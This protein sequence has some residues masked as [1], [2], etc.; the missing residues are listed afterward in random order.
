MAIQR[1]R[2]AVSP[3]D[4]LPEDFLS[5]ER[6]ALIIDGDKRELVIKD[7]LVITCIVLMML[8][9]FLTYGIIFLVGFEIMRGLPPG[10]LHWLGG[11]TIG[12]S[13]S[14]S[15]LVYKW[16]FGSPKNEKS[17]KNKPAKRKNKPA[18]S[19]NALPV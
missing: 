12:P 15:I 17:K 14:S 3:D 13:L 2:V 9:T 19:S 10:F 6:Q 8:S 7:R 4:I 11:A 1:G 18:K 16:M 5:E